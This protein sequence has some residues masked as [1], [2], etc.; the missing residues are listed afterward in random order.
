MFESIL[1]HPM[2]P[3]GLQLPEGWDFYH[4][5]LRQGSWH[6]KLAADADVFTRITKH[7]KGRVVVLSVDIQ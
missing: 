1:G 7:N 4:K 3:N 2:A 5:T 6:T